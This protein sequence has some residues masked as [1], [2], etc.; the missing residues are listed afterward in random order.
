LS[1]E[2]KQIGVAITSKDNKVAVFVNTGTYKLSYVAFQMPSIMM[3]CTKPNKFTN[4]NT[5]RS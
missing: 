4:N 5:D 1:N 2:T 3:Y